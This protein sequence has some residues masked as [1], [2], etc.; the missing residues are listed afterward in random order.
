MIKWSSL[1]SLLAP[2]RNQISREYFRL[3]I[4]GSFKEQAVLEQFCRL[5]GVRTER[6]VVTE[7]EGVAVTVLALYVS[8]STDGLSRCLA[9]FRCARRLSPVSYVVPGRGQVSV[10][11]HSAEGMAKVLRETEDLHLEECPSVAA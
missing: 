4:T 9:D 11:D 5:H 2:G 3:K 7:Y 6:A 1:L 10:A 8:G